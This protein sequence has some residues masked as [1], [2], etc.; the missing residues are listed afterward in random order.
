MDPTDFLPGLGVMLEKHF[1]RLGYYMMKPILLAVFAAFMLLPLIP[2]SAIAGQVASHASGTLEMR[3]IIRF[4]WWIAGLAIVLCL[5]WLAMNWMYR[6]HK[7]HTQ[8]QENEKTFK[9][10]ERQRKEV[11]TLIQ[12]AWI[13]KR[14][15]DEYSIKRHRDIDAYFEAQDKRLLEGM[16][17]LREGIDQLTEG[18]KRYHAARGTKDP[19]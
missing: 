16:S 18:W 8:H 17:R 10:V 9:E 15:V 2:I 4:V 19:P 1:G 14:W 5:Q 6:R 3:D 7:I 12:E 11:Q 13:L